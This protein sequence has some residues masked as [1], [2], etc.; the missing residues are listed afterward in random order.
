VPPVG[1]V[2]DGP[3]SG[4]TGSKGRGG[5]DGCA[6]LG[7]GEGA[8]RAACRGRGCGQGLQGY[9]AHKKPTPRRT[10]Q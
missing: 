6:E 1:R 3:A 4:E 9:L 8:D 7:G 5:G 10:L 2:L